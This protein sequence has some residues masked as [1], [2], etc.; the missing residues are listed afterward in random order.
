MMLPKLTNVRG[1]INN[2]ANR[3]NYATTSESS[4]IFYKHDY[5]LQHLIEQPPP[6]VDS[7]PQQDQPFAVYRSISRPVTI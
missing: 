5:S 6:G 1:I 3:A 4:L 7:Q 2:F